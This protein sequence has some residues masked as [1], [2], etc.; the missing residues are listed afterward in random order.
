MIVFYRYYAKSIFI[1]FYGST[2]VDAKIIQMQFEMEIC[3]NNKYTV[4]YSRLN[5]L[6][7]FTN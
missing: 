7:Q 2:V 6:N 3:I 5:R 1:I 4:I